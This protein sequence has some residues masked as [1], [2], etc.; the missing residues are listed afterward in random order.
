MKKEELIKLGISEEVAD[1]IVTAYS[2]EIQTITQERDTAVKKSEGFETQLKA[3]ND[4]I[5]AFGDI[6]PE[7]LKQKISD[8]EEKYNTDTSTLKNQLAEQESTYQT[9]KFFSGY[10]FTSDLAKN[11]AIAAFKEKGFKM[12]NGKFLGGDDFME[13]LKKSNPSAFDSGEGG[14]PK[15]IVGGGGGI[16]STI[17]AAQARSIMGLPAESK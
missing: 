11:A 5:S 7:E 12:E 10:K 13:E 4:T 6:K 9:E 2:G 17:D 15:I 16:G 3:A 1:Q 8:W 14:I